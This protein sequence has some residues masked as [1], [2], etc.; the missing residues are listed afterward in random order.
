[1]PVGVRNELPTVGTVLALPNVI[2]VPI[3]FVI[4]ERNSTSSLLEVDAIN[5]NSTK[6]QARL[7]LQGKEGTMHISDT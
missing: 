5:E 2:G 4:R 3:V 6:K 1:L 7:H